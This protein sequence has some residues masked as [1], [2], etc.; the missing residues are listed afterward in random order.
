MYLLKQWVEGS[1]SERYG[2]E[3]NFGHVLFGLSDIY[4][5]L[6]IELW[7]SSLEIRGRIWAA[8]PYFIII[9]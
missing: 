8:S 6:S 1:G 4:Y 5:V 7:R 2:H 3:F 9:S